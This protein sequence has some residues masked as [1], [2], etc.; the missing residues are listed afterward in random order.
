MCGRVCAAVPVAGAAISAMD[1]DA[2]REVVCASDEVIAEVEDLQFALGEGPALDT[3]TSGR[4]VLIADFRAPALEQRWPVLVPAASHLPI[5]ALFAFPMRLGAI[6]LGVCALYRTAAGPLAIPDLAA[7]LHAIDVA[8]L[9]LLSLRSGVLVDGHDPN[10]LGGHNQSRRVVHQATGMLIA[11]LGVPAEQGFARL[12][13]HA[14]AT[15]RSIE[16]VAADILAR[17]LRLEPDP[18]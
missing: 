2:V 14:Y 8:T 10:W 3:F 18:I 5:G 13:A 12:R 4:P 17:R 9:S 1:S 15:G 7:A 16:E 11:Q 6:S